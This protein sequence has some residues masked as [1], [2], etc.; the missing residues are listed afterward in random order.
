[1]KSEQGIV[2]ITKL[3][4]LINAGE[5]DK[6]LTIP[7]AS[8]QL[9]INTITSKSEKREATGGN[10]LLTDT[11]IKEC[12]NETLET[13]AYTFVSFV[14]NGLLLET[15]NGFELSKKGAIAIKESKVFNKDI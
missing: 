12:I 11:D 9:L 8:K 6:Y 4:A 1:M 7:F 15:E 3:T 13:A 10:P 2:F 5:Y 14:K